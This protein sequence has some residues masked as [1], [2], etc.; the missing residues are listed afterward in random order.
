[1]SVMSTYVDDGM[2][3]MRSCATKVRQRSEP[4]MMFSFPRME[5]LVGAAVGA[6]M[7]NLKRHLEVRL[8]DFHLVSSTW[9]EKKGID[10]GL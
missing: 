2:F 9:F 5:T 6:A 3:V 1:M 4:T 8:G 10:F 7:L